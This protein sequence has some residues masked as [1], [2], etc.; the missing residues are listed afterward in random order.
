MP[1]QSLRRLVLA[2][3]LA[4]SLSLTG[5]GLIDAPAPGGGFSASAEATLSTAPSPSGPPAEL[6]FAA[7]AELDETMLA[8][9]GDPLVADQDFTLTAQDD[10][11]GSWEYTRV[12]TQCTARFWQGTI[13]DIDTAQPDEAISD[14]MLATWYRTTPEEI[15]R[16][17][18][19]DAVGYQ[20]AGA[21]S[22]A[23]R[24]VAGST[25][26][27]ASYVAAAR[28]MGAIPAGLLVEIICPAG[29]DASAEFGDL[30]R[31][32]VIMVASPTG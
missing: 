1:R 24:I 11:N 5:C 16:F 28:G 30:Q 23:M 22:V 26:A 27:G 8:Q 13:D 19:E 17:A 32:L 29:Q 31:D 14:A 21:G 4:A 3:V 10:G 7:G 2:L 6:T 25:P 20:L 18:K 12:T 15:A 9:W